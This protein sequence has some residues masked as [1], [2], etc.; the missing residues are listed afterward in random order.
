MSRQIFIGGAD[1]LTRY[2]DINLK[3][4]SNVTITYANN[5][6][7]KKVDITI[8]S[9]GG[10]GGSVRSINSVS[11][12]TTAGSTSG[13]DYVYLVSGTT[14]ITLPTAVGNTNLYTIKNVGTGVVTIN[15]TSSQ[16][17]DG[18]LTVS[19]PVQYTAVDLISDTANW[20]VT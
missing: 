15:T 16:T 13:T 12:P 1:P 8:A 7:T 17:I 9:T 19:M 5:N 18:S 3:A 11:T 4:G 20:N 14:T 6:T 2:T 10:G